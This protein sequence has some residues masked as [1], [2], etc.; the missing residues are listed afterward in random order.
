MNINKTFAVAALLAVSGSVFAN[1]LLPFTELDN[2]KSTKT[3]AEVKAELALQLA[4]DR[5]ALVHRDFSPIDPVSA[6]A[7]LARAKNTA[8]VESIEAAKNSKSTASKSSGG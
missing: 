6:S 7:T 1:D 4:A 2:F 8:P 5:N 3:R